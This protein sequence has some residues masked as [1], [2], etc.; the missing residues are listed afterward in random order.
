MEEDKETD[1]VEEVE[2]DDK[3][4][5]TSN[6]GID[7]EDLLTLW[8]LVKTKHGDIRPEDEHERVLWG[9]FKVMFEPD[10]RSK[11]WRDL[12]GYTV[13]VWK[14]YD[15][16]GV[17]F[18]RS[19]RI[20]QLWCL[21]SDGLAAKWVHNYVRHWKMLLVGEQVMVLMIVVDLIWAA[22]YMYYSKLT[23]AGCEGNRFVISNRERIG[24]VLRFDD[25]KTTYEEKK[26]DETTR[27]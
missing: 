10:I 22:G 15:S 26:K 21:F 19:V 5:L 2:E 25:Y 23:S 14:L 1:E 17:H 8:K 24:W 13:S 3:A 11:V 12:Q 18:A 7:R 6:L 9:D 20:Q 16:C 27:T 4:K